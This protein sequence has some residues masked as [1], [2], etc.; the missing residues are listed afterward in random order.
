MIVLNAYTISLTLVAKRV[1]CIICTVLQHSLHTLCTDSILQNSGEDW[2]HMLIPFCN[3]LKAW[4]IL[5]LCKQ[6][7]Y[8]EHALD[9]HRKSWRKNAFSCAQDNPIG[10]VYGPCNFTGVSPPVKSGKNVYPYNIWS[11]GLNLVNY[12][13][14]SNDTT[15]LYSRAASSNL[16]VDRVR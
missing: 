4:G 12:L 10:S 1:I 5:F 13:S 9:K 6:S 2:H 11:Y 14:T 3:I 15:F 16:T 7:I 8:Q